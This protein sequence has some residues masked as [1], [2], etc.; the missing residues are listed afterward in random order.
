MPLLL[1]S[2]FVAIFDDL[3]KGHQKMLNIE[4]NFF[5]NIRL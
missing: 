3:E 5:E 1:R 4:R 2:Y